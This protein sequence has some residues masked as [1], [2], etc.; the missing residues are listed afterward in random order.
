L[1]LAVV[2]DS[3]SSLA[4]S[5]ARAG[6][7]S[8]DRLESIAAKSLV[9]E[10]TT[11][12]P[13]EAAAEAQPSRSADITYRAVEAAFDRARIL[14]W[15]ERVRSSDGPGALLILRPDPDGRRPSYPSAT[16]AYREVA[17]VVG[18]L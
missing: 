16:E 12:A 14:D 1:G 13:P 11:V 8:S 7:G 6:A 9:P 15:A 2:S 10:Q 5:N 18:A 3:I 4:I 17:E